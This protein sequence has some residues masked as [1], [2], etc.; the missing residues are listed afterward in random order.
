MEETMNKST[1]QDHNS[2]G[3]GIAIVAWNNESIIDVCLDSVQNQTHKKIKTIVLDNDSA[4][5]TAAIVK[6]NYPWANLIESN[7]NTGFSKGN[8][9]IIKQFMADKDIDYIVLLNSD[10]TIDP[11]WV[12]RLVQFAQDHEQLATAQGLT[13][14]FYDHNIVDS[15]HIYVNRSGQAIQAGYGQARITVRDQ[16]RKVFGVNA[17]ACMIS[18]K[19]LQNQPFDYVFD[20]DFFMYLEDVDFAARTFVMGWDN[21]IVPSAIAYHMGSTSSGKNPG[22]SVYMV[23]RNRLPMLIKNFPIIT[24]LRL[25]PRML[26][27]DIAE[28]Y[29]IARGKNYFIVYKFIMGRL[30]GLLITPLYISKRIKLSKFRKRSSKETW[31][32]MDAGAIS[33]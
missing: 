33:E 17:A 23:N 3:V 10:A 12:S 24:L 11:D 21:Y 30:K 32:A 2:L 7:K 15:T 18:K 4:D 1:N 13:L 29:R 19:F 22:F 6:E 25:L 31:L 27:A 26:I 14:D 9:I 20:E 28:L 8:N 16:P 5:N